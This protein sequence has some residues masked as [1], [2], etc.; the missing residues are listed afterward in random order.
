MRVILASIA[1]EPNRWVG[2]RE[3]QTPL[4]DL[5][6]QIRAAGFDK[7]EVWQWHVTSRCLAAARDLRK[8][9]D[10][11]GVSFPIIGVYPAFTLSG[12]EGRE[13][14]RM[15]ADALDKAE[16]LG[17]HA[18]KIMLGWGVKGS[19]IT[20]QQMDL[21]VARFG[22]WYGEAKARGI[23]MCAEL[24]GN[25]L[26]D[27]VDCGRTFMQA[28]PE[29]DFSIC[30]QPYDFIDTDRTLA[31]ADLFAGR[32]THLHLQAPQSQARGGM[33]DLLQEGTLGY[34][35]LLPHVLRRNPGATMTLEFVKDCIQPSGPFDRDRV[36][37][38][39]RR[40]A[41]FVEQVLTDAG[42]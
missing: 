31:L 28:H 16:I 1:V 36:L 2:Y 42:V 38:N 34:R 40:D 20:P 7:L 27:P 25:T 37:A 29:L 8:R 3:P 4:I 35:R 15:Q 14:D 39:A 26:F 21:T 24:H 23:G 32:I 19:A 41:E 30:F 5:L 10:E 12:A 18:L 9:G 13:Q 11:L 6:P 17:T 33:Y 22:R